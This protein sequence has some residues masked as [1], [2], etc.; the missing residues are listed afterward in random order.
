MSTTRFACPCCANLTLSEA[1]PGTFEICP[2]CYWEDDETQFR[3]PDYRG[4]A[5]VVS[6]NEAKSSYRSIGASAEEHT[7]V[8]RPPTLEE[9]PR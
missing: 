9:V 5:N 1:A 3:D 4:G 7:G 2:V 8:V 6:L